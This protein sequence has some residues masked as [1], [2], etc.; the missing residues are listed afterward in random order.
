MTDES[1]YEEYRNT[2]DEIVDGGG[3]VETMTAAEGLRRGET[4]RRDLL[5]SDA[6]AGSVSDVLA[7]VDAEDVRATLREGY[8]DLADVREAFRET[9]DLSLFD[10][11]AANGVDLAIDALTLDPAVCLKTF[12]EADLEEAITLVPTVHDDGVVGR[13]V[14]RTTVES[15][16][17]TIHAIPA[18]DR[19][20]AV[21]GTR[22]VLPDGTIEDCVDVSE[23]RTGVDCDPEQAA[24]A[25]YVQTVCPVDGETYV[26]ETAC[27][28]VR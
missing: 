2:L 3:C 6:L 14:V 19:S 27:S 8:D 20:Y 10:V 5:G 12:T 26:L 25:E 18:W 7:E 13:I 9:V 15:E 23:H 1:D 4:S 28:T 16:P 21:R 11:L 22:L 17:V 24:R